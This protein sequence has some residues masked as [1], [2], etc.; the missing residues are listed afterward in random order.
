MD[1]HLLATQRLG[2]LLA[3]LGS[4]VYLQH[5]SLVGSAACRIWRL[6]RLDDCV[7]EWPRISLLFELSYWWMQGWTLARVAV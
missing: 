5:V 3:Q 6:A 2:A 1:K 7:I 4:T